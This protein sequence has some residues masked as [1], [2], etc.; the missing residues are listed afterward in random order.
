MFATV[1]AFIAA[2]VEDTHDTHADETCEAC[3]GEWD[4]EW[5]GDRFSLCEAVKQGD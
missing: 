2:S 4:G 5:D 1:T 3:A